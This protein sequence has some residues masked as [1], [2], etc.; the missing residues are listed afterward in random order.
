MTVPAASN[1]VVQLTLDAT[2]S[3]P[4]IYTTLLTFTM[5]DSP[6]AM[7]SVPVTMVVRPAPK[8]R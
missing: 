6:Y 7:A 3:V 4:G 8:S 5:T 2:S 1:S